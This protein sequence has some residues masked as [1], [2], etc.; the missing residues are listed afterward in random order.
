MMTMMINTWPLDMV[1]NH[2]S[3]PSPPSYLSRH[4]K[5]RDIR[6]TL[7]TSVYSALGVS[8]IMRYM[9]QHFTYLLTLCS[10]SAISLSEPFSNT[11]FGKRAFCCSAPATWNSLPCTVTDS[12]T[13]GTFKSNLKTFLFCQAFN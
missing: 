3:N 1:S 2:F 12:D 4:I 5:A 13:L 10:S 11:A 9:N 7:S 8:A 6:R